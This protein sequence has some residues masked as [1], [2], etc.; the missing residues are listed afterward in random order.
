MSLY[1]DP[2]AR[3]SRTRFKAPRAVEP[4][5]A[6]LVPRPSGPGDITLLVDVI[7][8]VGIEGEDSF[9][10]F[11]STPGEEPS[12]SR[13]YDEAENDPEPSCFLAFSNVQ[14]WGDRLRELGFNCVEAEIGLATGSGGPSP[15]TVRIPFYAPVDPRQIETS[16][17]P[18]PSRSTSVQYTD[19]LTITGIDVDPGARERL[20]TEE[21][22]LVYQPASAPPEVVPG[23]H[24]PVD[25]ESEPATL[26]ISYRQQSTVP[27]PARPR[28]GMSTRQ[29][30][31]SLRF[32][33]RDV[34]S[35]VTLHVEPARFPNLV[36]ISSEKGLPGTIMSTG[37]LVDWPPAGAE[38]SGRADPSD[39]PVAPILRPRGNPFGAPTF[40][41]EDVESIGF[42]L[43]LS[44]FGARADALLERLV[45]P[46]NFH[47]HGRPGH[48][49][50]SVTP[51]RFRAA[52][53]TIVIE[54]LRYGRMMHP[55]SPELTP[56]DFTSQHELAVRLLVGRV[57]DD[58]AQAR[59]PAVFVPAIFVDNPL[60][61]VAGRELLGYGKQL[62]QFCL[63]EGGKQILE[64][65]GSLP[66]SPPQRPD[67][68]AIRALGMM[69]RV[70]RR[71]FQGRVLVKIT[72]PQTDIPGFG[73]TEFL[74]V[75][76]DSAP[77]GP[78]DQS[79]FA[80]P[81]FRRSF[82]QDV[83]TQGFL[84]FNWIQPVPVDDRDLPGAWITGRYTLHDVE[85][86]FPTGIATVE[87]MSPDAGSRAGDDVPASWRALCDLLGGPVALPTG[88]WYRLR[89]SMDL[90]IDDLLRR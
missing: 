75:S 2:R 76:E 79:D 14:T 65:S 83:V 70:D 18:Q 88:D 82:A 50:M 22:T 37:E 74:R 26:V 30:T 73:R 89:C 80:L 35:S 77:V 7:S 36:P 72:C 45:R 10:V 5:I 15:L 28:A 54:L 29:S 39:L 57:D 42:R 21:T 19:F 78:W 24:D 16:S 90:K 8:E 11:L 4:P 86:A 84:D 23:S 32:A 41:F 49:P 62:A 43:D 66:S 40:R 85:V 9:V 58:T 1:K 20:E 60:S 47:L 31:V 33:S 67:L 3:I 44:A 52:S 34:S 46:L 27:E 38:E 55:E 61:K 81:E 12:A 48:G 53:R 59:S 64:M 51:F 69:P 17:A 25:T 56:E 6:S 87:L 71:S 68:S 13:G 63:D